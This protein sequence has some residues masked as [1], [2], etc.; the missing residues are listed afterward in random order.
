M[1]GDTLCTTMQCRHATI[2]VGDPS[3][4]NPRLRRHHHPTR[5]VVRNTT[6]VTLPPGT[7]PALSKGQST[8]V[9]CFGLTG[10]WAR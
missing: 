4:V 8:A 2:A 3:P 10:M 1:A 7:S 9:L 5:L 6:V